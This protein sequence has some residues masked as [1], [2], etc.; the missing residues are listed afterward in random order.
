MVFDSTAITAAL[1]LARINLVLGATV[2]ILNGSNVDLV[3]VRKG[4]GAR[5]ELVDVV[6]GSLAK[7]GHIAGVFRDVAR[8]YGGV[9][10]LPG[11]VAGNKVLFTID[12][13]TLTTVT[14]ASTPATAAAAAAV[15]NTQMGTTIAYAMPGGTLMIQGA[16]VG[17]AGGSVVIA[18]GA[19]DAMANLG[20]TAAT[21]T[22]NSNVVDVD[23]TPVSDIVALFNASTRA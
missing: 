6:T 2:A 7:I 5:V 10:N 14:F 21:T 22:A 15:I 20:L 18:V 19:P 3:S 23:S 13:G 1:V 16:V 4:Y 12:G 11:I 17:K 9:T 8:V